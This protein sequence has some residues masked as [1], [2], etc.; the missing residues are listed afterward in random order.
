MNFVCMKE[1]TT[2]DYLMNLHKQ[3]MIEVGKFLK[4]LKENAPRNELILIR[5]NVKKLLA[6]IRRYPLSGN[7]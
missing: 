2:S 3:Y 1:I 7:K 5:M 4:A 6:E